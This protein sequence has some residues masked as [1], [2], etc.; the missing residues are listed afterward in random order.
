MK[1]KNDTKFKIDKENF[2]EFLATSSPEE[3]SRYIMEKGKPAKLVE[4]MIFFKPKNDKA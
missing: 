3:V 1:K 4:P 2:I